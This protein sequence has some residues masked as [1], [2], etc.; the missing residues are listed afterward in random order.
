MKN[1]KLVFYKIL[2][3]I[4]I[5]FAIIVIALI[6]KKYIGNQIN[7]E[8]NAQ[9]V[10]EIKQHEETT[11]PIKFGNNSVIGI[12]NI[13]KIELEYPILDT[14][15][16]E[17]M[18][19]SITRFSGGNVNEIGNLALAGHNNHDGTMFGRNDELVAG[20]KIYLTDLQKNTV[21]YEIK[22]IFVTDPN[23]V[24]ILETKEEIREVTLITCENGNKARLIIKAEEVKK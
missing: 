24:S 7:E 23:D 10:E 4:V 16:K 8:N 9:I 5:I 3:F 6:A 2:L 17:N 13:P 1:K 19:T 12:I 18:R 20:D 21:E 11:E 14:T 15:T 22:S